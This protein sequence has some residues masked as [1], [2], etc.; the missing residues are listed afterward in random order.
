MFAYLLFLYT[1]PIV[2]ILVGFPRLGL[3]LGSW[4]TMILVWI[5]S[6]LLGA[7]IGYF[8][9]VG[10]DTIFHNF[11][12]QTP[13][14]D[15]ALQIK[16]LFRMFLVMPWAV[17]YDA[18]INTWNLQWHAMSLWIFFF[19]AIGL[20]ANLMLWG[21]TANIVKTITFRQQLS[22]RGKNS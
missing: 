21:I 16:S 17:F 15:W 11:A 3:W 10:P 12:V 1:V 13:G 4:L 18:I 22:E 9:A 7:S 2:A 8:D 20:F 19:Q 5:F 14:Y 6:T